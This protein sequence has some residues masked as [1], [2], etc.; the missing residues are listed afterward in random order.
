MLRGGIVV[1]G[2]I[3]Y[4]L[5]IC[6]TSGM[7][8]WGYAYNPVNQRYYPNVIVL[9]QRQMK[10]APLISPPTAWYWL[11][12]N[13]GGDFHTSG[14]ITLCLNSSNPARPYIWRFSIFRRFTWPSTT[15]LL[16]RLL[17]ASHIASTSILA[18]THRSSAKA[19]SWTRV[20]QL[21][22]CDLF[23]VFWIR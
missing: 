21:L 10:S 17:I 19:L 23:W 8:N 4:I 3:N 9:C 12:C 13:L 1:A 15:P 11:F 2:S 16:Q 14:L 20:N 7:G 18:T 5:F 22:S 6:F